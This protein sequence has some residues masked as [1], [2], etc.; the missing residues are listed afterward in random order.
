MKKALK[1]T[2]PNNSVVT[3]STPLHKETVVLV[4]S[5]IKLYLRAHRGRMLLSV[6]APK[7]MQITTPKEIANFLDNVVDLKIK[8]SPT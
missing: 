4:G 6:E 1:Y 2:N 5:D 8:S 3:R 7:N